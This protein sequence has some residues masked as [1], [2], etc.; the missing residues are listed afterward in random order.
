MSS[1][2]DKEVS[3]KAETISLAIWRGFLCHL[4][5]MLLIMSTCS[6]GMPKVD[7][8]SDGDGELSTESAG[9]N[10]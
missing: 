10:C 1:D 5:T 4:S 8:L 9:V 6:G 2:Q 3:T 7:S